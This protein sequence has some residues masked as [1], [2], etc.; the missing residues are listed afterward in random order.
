M[1]LQLLHPETGLS[2][3]ALSKPANRWMLMTWDAEG[4]YLETH[5]FRS[6][7]AGLRA[8]AAHYERI[9]PQAQTQT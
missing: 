7:L 3:A 9:L 2:L 5:L 1:K 6:K 8:M 4:R